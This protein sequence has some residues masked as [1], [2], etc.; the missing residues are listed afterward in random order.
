MRTLDRLLAQRH[1]SPR[2][3]SA[4]RDGIRLMIQFAC[5]QTGKQPSQLD[6][7]DLDGP[8][9]IGPAWSA[10]YLNRTRLLKSQLALVV[11]E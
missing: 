2:T 1:S 11:K 7:A 8:V 10:D 4:Y 6:F 5:S 9:G 3:V